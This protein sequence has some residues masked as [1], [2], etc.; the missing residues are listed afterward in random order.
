MAASS[1]R[2]KP[3][4][5]Q[6]WLR[7][8]GLTSWQA[9]PDE[10][11]NKGSPGAALL[12]CD[13]LGCIYTARDTKVA[14][15]RDGRGLRDDCGRVEVLVSLEPLRRIP[16]HRPSVIVDRFDLWRGGAHA[17]WLDPEPTVES[18][19]A[20]RGDRPWVRRRTPASSEG[21]KAGFKRSN[22]AASGR[23]DGPG[24]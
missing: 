16:C 24:P 23:P 3:F 15:L 9:W 4:E 19:N 5:R 22:T 14:L 17:I 12:R 8:A 1:Q 11:R 21:P 20:R 18:V 7:R 2:L 6:I 10:S 13:A